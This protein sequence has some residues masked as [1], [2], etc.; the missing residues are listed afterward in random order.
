[1]GNAAGNKAC[2]GGHYKP[3]SRSCGLTCEQWEP[4]KGCN[5]L[6]ISYTRCGIK[7]DFEGTSIY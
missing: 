5:R 6:Y 4:L 7:E 1:M 3:D 2:H